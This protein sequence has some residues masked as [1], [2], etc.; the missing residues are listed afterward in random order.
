[1]NSDDGFSREVS[2]RLYKAFREAARKKRGTTDENLFEMRLHENLALLH[3]EIM[4]GEYH[5]SPG[6]AFISED[7]VVR[8]IFAAPFR[9]RVIHH[10]LFDIVN[11][12]WDKRLNYDAYSCRKGKGTMFGIF[13]LEQNI[14]KVSR[15]FTRPVM[16]A[17]FDIK[18]YFMSLPRKG[19][20]ERVMWGMDRQF[21][22][23]G[24]L[25]D[26]AKYLWYE[27]IFDDPTIGVRK[28]GGP[29]KW[30]LLPDGKS[31]FDQAPGKGIV[32]GNLSSQLLSN[33]YLDPFD[34]F[35]TQSLGYKYYG[36]YVD[37]FYIVIPM[38]EKDKL[39]ADVKMIELKLQELGLVLHPK[40]R[41]F[42]EASKGVEFLGM[43]VYP[44]HIVPGHRIVHNFYE[45]L[46]G[47]E[48]GRKDETSIVSYMGLLKH[49][50]SKTAQARIFH[51]AG[52]DYQF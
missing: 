5:P 6:I 30:A 28:R 41:Y 46:V 22:N 45:S 2:Q 52:Q 4:R 35:V 48:M 36:R 15:N 50:N 31:L 21:P 47:F 25:Y 37:D 32:I 23:G 39:L 49:Y 17:K 26:L 8:E 42:Q 12:W 29:E 33:M 13:R 44:G 11:E 38:E 34:R 1:M 16:V 20:Y 40:K 10:F 51:R 24:P 27:I 3:R 14:R 43:V 18:S 9:D 7:P 19:L